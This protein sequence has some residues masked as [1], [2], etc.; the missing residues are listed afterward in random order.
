MKK[1]I[2]DSYKKLL[3]NQIENGEIR[4]VFTG[5]NKVGKIIYVFIMIDDMYIMD[6]RIECPDYKDTTDEMRKRYVQECIY[7]YC[8]FKGDSVE[9]PRS[10]DEFLKSDK[11]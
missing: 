5:R 1:E 4:T 2:A 10:Y 6:M 11:K 3:Q 8:G 7:R 9:E